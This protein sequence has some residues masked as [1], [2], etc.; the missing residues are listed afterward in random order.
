MCNIMHKLL[1]IIKWCLNCSQLVIDGLLRLTMTRSISTFIALQ[2]DSSFDCDW[3]GNLAV[4][5]QSSRFG[6]NIMVISSLILMFFRMMSTPTFYAV[7]FKYVGSVTFFD[8]VPK[9][10][11]DFVTKMCNFELH[12]Q[13]RKCGLSK[14]EAT[15]EECSALPTLCPDTKKG[16]QEL[17]TKLHKHFLEQK[18]TR[19]ISF[20]KDP[21]PFVLQATKCQ[22][23]E[24]KGSSC[25]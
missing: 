22:C 7:F 15:K 19:I 16:E 11:P 1:V 20:W 8:N 4:F 25:E 13:K 2:L 12:G 6:W 18:W 14:H 24:N 10:V 9:H 17:W 21:L 3:L 23:I 5:L